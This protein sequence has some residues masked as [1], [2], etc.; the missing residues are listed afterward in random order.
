MRDLSKEMI[1]LSEQVCEAHEAAIDNERWD[2]ATEL[3]KL[4]QQVAVLVA[5]SLRGELARVS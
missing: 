2:V 3:L 1:K 5:K 4:G